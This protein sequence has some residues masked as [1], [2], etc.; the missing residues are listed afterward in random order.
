MLC[1]FPLIWSLKTINFP[2]MA[3]DFYKGSTNGMENINVSSSNF[4]KVTSN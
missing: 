1:N 3:F 4:G 2:E